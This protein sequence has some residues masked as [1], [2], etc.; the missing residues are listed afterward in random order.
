VIAD[1]KVLPEALDRTYARVRR[2]LET[3]I[4][5]RAKRR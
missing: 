2:A 3:E 5:R 4:A 1:T